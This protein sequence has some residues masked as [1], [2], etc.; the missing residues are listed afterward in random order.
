MQVEAG[1]I[2][3]RMPSSEHGRFADDAIWGDLGLPQITRALEHKEAS[4]AP[5]NMVMFV[6]D[7]IDFSSRFRPIAG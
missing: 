4:I 6:N 5:P 7:P 2:I 1:R 3:M